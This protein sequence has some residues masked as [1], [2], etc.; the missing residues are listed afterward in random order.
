MQKNRI[1]ALQE[2]LKEKQI[3][4][5][6]ITNF[7]NIVYLTGFKTLTSHERESFVLITQKNVYLF[8]DARYQNDSIVF[9]QFKLLTAGNGL[10]KQLD[11]IVKEEGIKILG[12]EKE[13]LKWS[14]Y[15]AIKTS[16]KI[17]L[18]PLDKIIIQLR[19]IKDKYEIDNIKKACKVGD[20]SLIELIPYMKFGKSEKEIAFLFEK[21][22]RGKEC[23]LSFDP[24][25]A[26][27][28]NSS[29]PHYNTKTGKGKIN[30][31]SIILIDCGVNYQ[32]YCSDITRVFFVNNIS[33]IMKKKYLSLKQIHQQT[34]NQI[35][36][37][38]KLSEI[39]LYCR[40][41]MVD[42]GLPNYPHST[43]HGVGLEVHEYPKV[44]TFSTEQIMRSSVFTIEPG[45]Y[46][47][48]EWGMRIEDTVYLDKEG[49]CNILTQFSKEIILL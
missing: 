29:I 25:V 1:K 15:E 30:H 46:F 38:G 12:F 7:Y 6:L 10:I 26:I 45:I 14:E 33:E 41:Q 8:S 16:A 48:D 23:E 9:V 37:G 2:I 31:S 39:D 34:I 11:E 43:G 40:R 47:P 28:K 24:I 13:D 20:Q 18:F 4:A 35:K 27:D 44:S 36:E 3:D 21:I 32:G 22:V 19:A 42:C 5:F 49:N 17:E